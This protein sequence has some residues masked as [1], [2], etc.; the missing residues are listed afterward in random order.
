M[1]VAMWVKI[2]DVLN[3]LVTNTSMHQNNDRMT[4]RDIIYRHEILTVNIYLKL[5]QYKT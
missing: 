1:K 4:D 3:S 5:T 2:M